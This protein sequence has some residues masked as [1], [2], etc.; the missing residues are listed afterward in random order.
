MN[1]WRSRLCSTGLRHAWRCQQWRVHSSMRRKGRLP[2]CS[3]QCRS[4]ISNVTGNIDSFLQKQSAANQDAAANSTAAAANRRRHASHWE[5]A[6]AAP[7]LLMHLHL[8]LPV[9]AAAA[10]LPAGM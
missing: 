6:T 4:S 10:P 1:A 8:N 2:A 3:M 9:V 7:A 5:P